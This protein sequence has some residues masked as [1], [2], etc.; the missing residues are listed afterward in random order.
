[1]RTKRKR[2]REQPAK[3]R[4]KCIVETEDPCSICLEHMVPNN[5][6]KEFLP[7]FHSFHTT[8]ISQ[9]FLRSNLCPICRFRCR[10]ETNDDLALVFHELEFLSVVL[11]IQRALA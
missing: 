11:A 6:S 8:C 10:E 1:M 5:N 2:V 9:W 7:C 4:R 3:K